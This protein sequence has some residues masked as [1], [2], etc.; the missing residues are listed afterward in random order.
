MDFFKDQSE[1]LARSRN[2]AYQEY[3]SR[4]EEAL[5]SEDGE[6]FHKLTTRELVTRE[7]YNEHGKTINQML[8]TTLESF[9]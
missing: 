3:K 2:S 6:L 8:K 9:P 7:F 1:S 4:Y 5:L